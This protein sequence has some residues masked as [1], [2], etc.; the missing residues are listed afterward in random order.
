MRLYPP[1]IT[2]KLGFDQIKEAAID[3][4]MS[5]R[6]REKLEVWTA[7]SDPKEVHLW[8]NETK[9]MM[10]ILRNPDPFPLDQVPEIRDFLSQ[11]S[12]EDSIIALAA[13]VKIFKVSTI[14]RRTRKF[15]KRNHEEYPDCKRV[16]EGIV[17]LKELEQEIKGKVTE[18]G[19]LRDDASPELK[20]IRKQIN[21]KKND[22]RSTINRIMKNATKDGMTSDE[23]ATIRN[24]R[25]V[26]PIQAEYKRKV[27]GFVHDVSSTGQTVYLEP[28]E[29][30]HLNN[31]IRQ[32]EAEEQNE[33]ERILRSLTRQVRVNTPF[34]RQN[35]EA[36]SDLDLIVC[37]A[38]VSLLLEGDI[39]I[40]SD[41]VI[42]DLKKAENPILKL[43]NTKLKPSEREKIIPLDL[44]LEEDERCLMVTGP[45]A[46]GKSV[47]MKTIGLCSMMIQAGFGIPADP[48]SELPIFR[49][50]FV[51]MG[52]DQSIE[53]DL[54][55]FSS[56]LKWMQETVDNF[57]KGSLV[58]IDEAAAGTD[59]DEGSA[60]FQALLEHLLRSHCKIVVTTHHGSLKVFAHEHQYAI[61][62]SMEFDQ[63]NLSPTY[64]FKKGIP[65]SS[66]AFEI[67]QRMNISKPILDRSREL[68]GEAKEAMESLISE[69]ETRTQEAN[70]LK[71]K[72]D[73][74]YSKTEKDKNRYENKLAS[75]D[76]EKEKIREKALKEAKHIMDTANQRIESAVQ[77][78]IEKDKADK[79]EIRQIRKDVDEQKVDIEES[80]NEI[81]DQKTARERTSKEP[82]KVGDAV[83][84]KDGN[85]T[86]ELVEMQ[87]KKAVVL[88]GGL[89]L[90][91][92]YKNLIKVE[93][94]ER[95]KKTKSRARSSI[96]VGDSD[97]TSEAM[98]PSL[99]VR[100]LRADEALKEVTKYLDKAIFRGINRV[101]IVHGKG[102]GILKDQ[103]QSYL[104]T[105]DDVKSFELAP[106]DQG[107]AGCTVVH[108]K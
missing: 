24:G 29:A 21:G 26:I 76:R 46:G 104:H 7:S 28:V 59:P 8:L 107:G 6:T 63:E 71:K 34:L 40:V 23:G 45:N 97:L 51:D 3:A 75:I 92:N 108:L 95:K 33:I 67:A 77:Q 18:Y 37:R 11:A 96:I 53:N 49:G 65:G 85:T 5:D 4:A 31:E 56:R 90:K 52:D 83:R 98:K 55:T 99:H 94:V 43:K 87:G 66:Y 36:L 84:F 48:T 57:E 60:L 20:R 72:Y 16:S 32:L 80:L 41:Q 69:L 30:L 79:D 9:E 13:F 89:T 82:P 61:N 88:A 15:F 102:D 106:V 38:K 103:I 100:G 78:I 58:L 62:G 19:E 81:E 44:R 70:E 50:F 14:S 68:V 42:L 17:P 2:E 10:D 27:Q 105:R 64:Q 35:I 101:E 91:T 39:P 25:M 93:K 74:L 1:S 86:G 12:A 73:E 54:S 22:L 47:A